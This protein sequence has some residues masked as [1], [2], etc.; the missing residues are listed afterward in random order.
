MTSAVLDKNKIATVVGNIVVY[1]FSAQTGEYTGSNVEYLPIGIGLPAYSTETE[2]EVAKEGYVSV[3][4]GVE[5][6]Q[7]EDHRGETVYSVQD[8]T[9]VT[10][11]YIGAIRNSFTTSAPTSP[12]DKWDGDKWVTDFAAQHAAA[13]SVAVSYQQQ[14]I[15]SAMQSISVIQLKLQAGRMLTGAET[16]KLNAMLDYIDAV[17]AVDTATAPD[18]SWPALAV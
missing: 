16:T 11:D 4:N 17:N 6:E 1:N 2:P 18:V 15:D 14:L 3:F 5:W 7:K 10:I 8:R 9:P 13:V 12:F